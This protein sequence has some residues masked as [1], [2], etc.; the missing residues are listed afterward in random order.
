MMQDNFTDQEYFKDAEPI[1]IKKEVGYYLFFW[2]Y[3]VA[4]ITIALVSAFLYLKTA[5][6]IYTTSSQLQ[7]NKSAEDATS[8][9]TGGVDIFGFDQVNVENDIAVLNSQHIL[10][11]VVERLDLQTKIYTV[12]RVN[13]SFRFNDKYTRFISINAPNKYGFWDI[14]ILNNKAIFTQDTLSFI[15]NKGDNF[16]HKDTEIKLNDS[17]FLENQTLKIQKY[18]LN[19]AVASLRSSLTI[20]PASDRG[21]IINLNFQ[22]V[23]KSRN[24]AILNTIMQ[25]LKDDQVEDKRLISKVSLAFINERLDG[26]KKSI[27]TVSKNTIAYQL[28]NS[29]F[30]P[31]LQTGNALSNII[32]G[33][34]ASFN[35]SIQLE[36]AKALLSKLESQANYQILPANIGI[37]NESVNTLVNSYNQVITK[38]NNLLI[39]ATVNSPVVIE[40]SSQLDNAKAAI[41]IGVNRYIEGLQTSLSGYQQMEN[42]TKGIVASLPSKENT[43]RAYARDFKIGEE[44][45]IYLLQRK[46]EA[47]ISYI[48]ALSNIKILSKGVSS[49]APISPKIQF[50]YI[51]AFLLGILTPLGILFLLK[52]LDTKINTKDDLEKGLKG[53]T[54]LGEMPFTDTPNIQDD[55]GRGLIAESTRVLRAGLS[56]QLN[57]DI[58][59]II[60]VTSTIKGEGKSF[61]SYNLAKS[62]SALGKKVI[63]VGADLRNPQL[64][65]FLGEKRKNNGLTTY[66]SNENFNDIDSLITKASTDVGLDYLLTGAIPPNPSELLMRPRM[67]EL[68]EVLK[69]SYDFIIIDSAPLLL[70]SDTTAILPICDSVVYVTRSQF[71]EKKLFSFILDMQ[72]RENVP[73]FA[74]V[75]NGMRAGAN[76]GY[77]YGY[78][79]RYSYG[80]TYNY[81]YGYGYGIDSK[82]ES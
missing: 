59:N 29:I 51:V 70:V 36:I 74:M 41:I 24:E 11:Q 28:E 67:K 6:R 45:Y 9:L 79:Y 4:T 2:P 80:Y 31:V 61:V 38:R 73:P 57:S 20:T 50:T 75:L 81:G 17:L 64:H 13:S 1:D 58:T 60:C 3:F 62:Y 19:Q 30:D 71:S 46:E 48:S 22:G 77:N 16:V 35:I 53:I 23:N 25:V 78:K 5:D 12:G 82:K 54:I 65:K 27:D 34:E 68:L 47:S 8:F 49:N 15:I 56:F 14:E 52:I 44:L 18:P 43:L 26:L 42:K 7:I 10:S 72:Q 21:E 63:L 32:K 66:L 39:S 37:E 33:Q 55:S 40:L 76:N 69:Q